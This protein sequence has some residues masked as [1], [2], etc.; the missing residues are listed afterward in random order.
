MAEENLVLTS[1]EY[2]ELANDQIDRGKID[3]A[4]TSYTK[5]IEVDSICCKAYFERGVIYERLKKFSN[6][7]NDY[8]KAIEIDPNH[9]DAYLSRAIC[10]LNLKDEEGSCLD[11][12]KAA[13][14]GNEKAVN[15]LNSS[16]GSWCSEMK[17]NH[18]LR[19]ACMEHWE[20]KEYKEAIKCLDRLIAFEPE[21]TELHVNRASCL[22]ML[23]DTK[24]AINAYNHVL[25]IDPKNWSAYYSRGVTLRDSGDKEGA[26]N[27]F[28]KAIELNPE[29]A[30]AFRNRG[31]L[32][33]DKKDI[34]SACDDWKKAAE[35]GDETS[36]LLL[37]KHCTDFDSKSDQDEFTATPISIDAFCICIETNTMALKWDKELDMSI[38]T[39]TTLWN[40]MLST[41]PETIINDAYCE[42]DFD[43]DCN[44]NE[45]VMSKLRILKERMTDV[46]SLKEWVEDGLNESEIE[47]E[48]DPDDIGLRK[49]DIGNTDD[50][51]YRDKQSF[52]SDID[53]EM[54]IVIILKAWNDCRSE[55]EVKKAT[56]FKQVIDRAYNSK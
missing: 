31:N 19:S 44:E 46:D 37:K 23:G 51:R 50:C 45:V 47:G 24:S 29:H 49:W 40:I 27:D 2:I 12:K 6:A 43:D 17:E 15:Y 8:N 11:Y 34:K 4:I 21:N 54:V 35:L 7:I 30:W 13:S 33:L 52:I 28:S 56:Q 25:D 16:H 55:D 14:L 26:I 3:W 41:D 22:D 53:W 38:A 32:K 1:K 10:K 5:A 36:V 9:Q 39:Y 42:D 18:T 48:L 20:N